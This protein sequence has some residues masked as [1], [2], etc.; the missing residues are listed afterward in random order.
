M[1]NNKK[2][3]FLNIFFQKKYKDLNSDIYIKIIKKNNPT[4]GV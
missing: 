4:S 2:I 1:I 3:Y